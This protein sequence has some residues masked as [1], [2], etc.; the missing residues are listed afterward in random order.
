MVYLKLQPYR[1]STFG[2]HSSLKLQSK[3][4]G[5]FRV[6][7]IV[8]SV[9]YKLQL[10]THVQIHPVFHVS[11][12]KRH[13]GP[14]AIRN[15]NLPLVDVHIHIK[16][17]PV[18]VLQT[19]QIPRNHVAVVQWL[20]EWANLPPDDATWEDASFIKSMYP[21]FYNDTIR[22]WFQILLLLDNKFVLRRGH[23]QYC[24]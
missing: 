11:Q 18:V 2:L 1:I 21:V 3:Y 8:G 10:P 15:P 23:C 13:L 7:S 17:E 20:V 14:T 19:R 5:P 4:Y 6:L 22:S 24:R 12:L 16:T 9:A